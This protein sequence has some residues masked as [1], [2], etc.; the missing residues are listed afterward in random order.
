MRYLNLFKMF[1]GLKDKLDLLVFFFFCSQ[2]K[3]EYLKNNKKTI[4]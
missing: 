3:W 1:K 4:A 2:K